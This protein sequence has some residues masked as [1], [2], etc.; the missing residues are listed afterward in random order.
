MNDRQEELKNTLRDQIEERNLKKK[1]SKDIN[2]EYV[3]Y[4]RDKVERDL[5]RER[6]EIEEHKVKQKEVQQHIL[7]QIEEKRLRTKGM[8][9]E[10]FEF[11]KDLL[12]E[13]ASKRKELKDSIMEAKTESAVRETETQNRPLY[14][15]YNL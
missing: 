11:N 2:N 5:A 6:R 7:K 15:I 10:E 13:I 8:S 4:F 14:E 3:K 12:K 1:L 9:V